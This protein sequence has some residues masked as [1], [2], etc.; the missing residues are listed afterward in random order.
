MGCGVG[1]TAPLFD[2]AE[3]IEDPAV[4]AGPSSADG[5]VHLTVNVNVEPL[6]G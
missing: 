3:S 6:P 1:M 5:T 2:I 4:T